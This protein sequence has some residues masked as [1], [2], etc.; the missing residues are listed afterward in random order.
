MARIVAIDYGTKRTG[1]A[2]TDPLQIIATALDTVRSHELIDFLKR[3]TAT[4]AVEAFVVGMPRKLDNTDTN[5]TPHVKGFIKQLKKAF[6][7]TPVYEHDERFT[8]SMAL[9]TMISMGTK[10]SDR[11]DKSNIDKMSATII[12]QSYL[13]TKK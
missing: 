5:N 11:Q 12:L 8:S 1:I 6:P 9:Q 2:V 13:T 7:E 3:Y 10:K 4:E